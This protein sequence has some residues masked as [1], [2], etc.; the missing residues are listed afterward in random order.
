MHTQVQVY[1]IELVVLV[2][3]HTPD[4]VHSYD[5]TRVLKVGLVVGGEVADSVSP[6]CLH[7]NNY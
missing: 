6:D 1:F 4:H 3:V 7:T 5:V 2:A